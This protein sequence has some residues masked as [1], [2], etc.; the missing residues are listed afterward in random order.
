MS[1]L[2]VPVL[3]VVTG[4]GGS[5]GALALAVADRVLMLEHAVYSVLSPEGFASILWKDSARSADAAKLM[6][7][8]AHDLYQGGVVEEVLPEPPGGAQ[9]DWEATFRTVDAALWRELGPL[10]KLSGQNWRRAVIAGSRS[11]D[12]Q[13]R[14]NY[15][16]TGDPVHGELCSHTSGHQ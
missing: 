4:E 8:T 7:L 13:E 10:L 5:G 15:E 12:R 16:R 11:W 9:T 1:G 3:T 6:H 2:T 14:S